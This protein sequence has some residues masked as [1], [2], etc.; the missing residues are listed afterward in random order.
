MHSITQISIAPSID[1]VW[2][3]EKI[4]AHGHREGYAWLLCNGPADL[5]AAWYTL[6]NACGASLDSLDWDIDGDLIRFWYVYC[7]PEG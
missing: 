3:R 2:R 5:E 6:E 7:T 4:S 1:I